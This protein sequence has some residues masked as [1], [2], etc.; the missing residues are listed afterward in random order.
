MSDR[1]AALMEWIDGDA[2][3]IDGCDDAI[4]GVGSRCGHQNLFVY[5]YDLLMAAFI[6]DGMTEEEAE[7]WIDYNI[8]GCWMGEGTPIVLRQ[9]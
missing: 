2:L 5:D 8:L 4:I 1:V 3:V 9:V 6:K 7:E